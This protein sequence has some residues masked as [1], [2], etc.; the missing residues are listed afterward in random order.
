LFN[1]AELDAFD[2]GTEVILVQQTRELP[3]GQA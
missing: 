2:V 1:A 3:P